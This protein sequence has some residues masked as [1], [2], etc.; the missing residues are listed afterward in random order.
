MKVINN[1]LYISIGICSGTTILKGNEVVRCLHLLTINI[2]KFKRSRMVRNHSM[3][4]GQENEVK[5]NYFVKWFQT[6]QSTIIS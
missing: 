2:F 5:P 1:K 3:Q 6:I 4:Q